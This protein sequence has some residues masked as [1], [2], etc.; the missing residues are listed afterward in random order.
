MLA[1]ADAD[2]AAI[3]ADL[4]YEVTVDGTV[5][6]RLKADVIQDLVIVCHYSIS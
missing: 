4:R 3:A 1:V 5:H 6:H 2:I